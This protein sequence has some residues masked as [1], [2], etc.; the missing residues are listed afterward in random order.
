MVEVI[1]CRLIWTFWTNKN[2]KTM[3]IFIMIQPLTSENW[4]ELSKHLPLPYRSD[5]KN[6]PLSNFK[7][8]QTVIHVFIS[9]NSRGEPYGLMCRDSK[10]RLL[11]HDFGAMAKT[12]MKI[13]R[14]VSYNTSTEEKKRQ[15]FVKSNQRDKTMA[16]LNFAHNRDW[17]AI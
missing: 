14:V 16:R 11:K 17:C 2:V 3:N 6:E 15:S 8:R 1:Y 12:D 4:V 10:T 5:P 13:I 9:W 7:S